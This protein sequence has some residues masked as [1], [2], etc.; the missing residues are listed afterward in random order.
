MFLVES[1]KLESTN[2]KFR[3]DVGSNMCLEKKDRMDN[4]TAVMLLWY[5][6]RSPGPTF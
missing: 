2:Y 1:L 4:D 3:Q 6:T 5:V